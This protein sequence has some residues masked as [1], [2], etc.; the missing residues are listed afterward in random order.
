MV[1]LRTLGEA[2]VF[3]G[4]WSPDTTPEAG[5]ALA[6]LAY[7][8]AHRDRRVHRD[9]LLSLLWGG[10]EDGRARNS[11]R[12]LIYSIRRRFG[13]A[14]IEGDDSSLRIGGGVQSDHRAYLAA[15]GRGAAPE[16]VARYTGPFLL[17]FAVPG[18]RD[19][20][21]WAA[22][23]RRWLSHAFVR[24]AE[25]VIHDALT[26]GRPREVL[27]VARR[28][29][30]EDP[31]RQAGWRQLI[32]LL[33]ASGDW[34][35]A[36]AES[37]ALMHALEVDGQEPE[38]TTT[39]LLRRLSRQ[40]VSSS[41]T[42]LTRV[43][44]VGRESE[45]G[46]LVSAWSRSREGRRLAVHIE[47][48]AGL[49]KTR[50]LQ[51][52]HSR[53]KIVGARAVSARAHS[54]ERGVAWSLAADIVGAIGLLPGALSV[55]PS[56]VPHLLAMAPSLGRIF[57]RASTARITQD[58]R[59]HRSRAL[60]ALLDGVSQEVPLALLVDDLHW[61]DDVSREALAVAVQR[62]DPSRPLLLVSASR[63]S[64]GAWRVQPDDAIQLAPFSERE[65]D[66]LIE[67][68]ARKPD[69]AFAQQ[70]A[71]GVFHE[72]AGV[73]HEALS[74][75]RECLDTG[76]L[77]IRDGT[78]IVRDPGRFAHP[79]IG[80]SLARTL[81][82]LEPDE[83]KVL[84]ILAASGGP[85]SPSLLET[86]LEAGIG[87][88]QVHLDHLMGRGLVRLEPDGWDVAHDRVRE[89]VTT[90]CGELGHWHAA[91][92]RS[93]LDNPSPGLR[94]IRKA[95]VHIRQSGDPL[96]LRQLGKACHRVRVEREDGRSLDRLVSEWLEVSGEDPC[97]EPILRGVPWHRRLARRSRLS[98]GAL[99]LT[100]VALL[101]SVALVP[102]ASLHL[103]IIPL[104]VQPFTPD[105]VIELRPSRWQPA[106]ASPETVHVELV[107]GPG[108]LTGRRSQVAVNGR[109]QFSELAVTTKGKYVLR[110]SSTGYRP[111][112]T[113]TF[114]VGSVQARLR[115]V[116]GQ[117]GDQTIHEGDTLMVAPG[118]RI[119]GWVQTRYST[120]WPA[121]SVLLCG[122]VSWSNAGAGTF[123]LSALVTPARDVIRRD[124]IELQAPATSGLHL[125]V[126]ALA[127]ETDCEDV[128]SS[129]NWTIGR[130]EWNDGNDVVP[131]VQEH[132]ETARREGRIVVPI[133]RSNS[134][135]GQRALVPTPVVVAPISVRVTPASGRLTPK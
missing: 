78:W 98:V 131:A 68:I 115:V 42:E 12:Q 38:T 6:L 61:A 7:L 54:G 43:D 89:A 30:D 1:T 2:G 21:E 126:L 72:S 5:K 104:P 27:E 34:M 93:L 37:A 66:A 94:W 23:E 49:G 39:A 25:S 20:E 84:E 119:K 57:P 3:A 31:G 129:T 108:A 50:L 121:A 87:G 128:M 56:T 92:G 8:D 97:M 18:G 9:E 10:K 29:R 74:L 86:L 33:V 77:E 132:L 52:F 65:I 14:A 105:P 15:V 59:L 95:A 32:E 107:S 135:F 124:Q 99:A 28:V 16:V 53:L 40:S 19:F 83:T 106:K 58:V 55:D 35:S 26:Q 114:D 110:F 82:T 81:A 69:D 67:E 118:A 62:L 36:A 100:V 134:E 116:T 75:L 90:G 80:T 48:V 70:F 122:G 47:G 127:A 22:V 73:P 13:S 4:A 103:A 71:S 112:H 24:A 109:A 85:L 60:H 91:I 120:G 64:S 45:F 125:I 51:E 63:P 79:D 102:D 17:G 123:T 96:L 113:D 44:F 130:A 41:D 76:V 11:L 133:R 111:L 101:G 117:F 88:L 46:R